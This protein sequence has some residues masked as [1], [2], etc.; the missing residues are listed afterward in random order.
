[1]NVERMT[2]RHVE[3]AANIL[4]TAVE[5]VRRKDVSRTGVR[6]YREGLVGVAGA[7]GD[8]DAVE[9]QAEAEAVLSRGVEYPFAV[10][11][12]RTLHIEE[13]PDLPDPASL[14]S[15]AESLLEELSSEVPELIFSGSARRYR[16]DTS[17]VNDAGLDLSCSVDG[18]ALDLMFKHRN[19]TGIMD[20]VVHPSSIRRWDRAAYLEEALAFCRAFL[21]DVALPAAGTL[22]VIFPHDAFGQPLSKVMGELNG[23]RFGSGASLLSGKAGRK[24]FSEM[25]TLE[26]CLD[27]ALGST[28]FFDDEGTV[29]EGFRHPLVENGVV[30]AP[31]TDK[32]TAA[33]FGLG[34]T[35][36]AACEY[37]GVP[38]LGYPGAEPST[39]EK[40]LAEILDGR[41]GIFVAMASGGE[42]TPDGG[43]ATPVQLGFLCEGGRLAGRL[44]ELGISSNMYDMLGDGYMGV[45]RDSLSRVSD[46]RCM[47]ISMKVETA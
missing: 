25:F 35:G 40:T 32:R 31:Y 5:S 22:P 34:L 44:P 3:I 18:M 7:I 15:E 30:A 4:R 29:N 24:L 6:V 26:Q 17:I 12:G 23:I 19:S 16:D 11:S 20:G 46:L 9:K 33:R 36:A 39:C 38:Q 41:P 42:F 28:A 47:V 2:K 27:P 8:F 1:M 45:S 21:N 37:D 14:P 10:S 13:R 43:Y